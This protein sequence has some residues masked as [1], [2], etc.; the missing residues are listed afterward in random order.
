MKTLIL[1]SLLTIFTFSIN[2]QGRRSTIYTDALK[3]DKNMERIGSV[4][5]VIGGVSL[6]IGNVLYW[7]VYH[8]NSGTSSDY[9][10]TY[11]DVMLGG[12]G[13]LAVGIPVWSAGK[14]NE[15]HIRIDAQLVRFKGVASTN[16]IGFKIRF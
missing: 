4:L 5:T 6:F 15:R 7:R 16:G 14:A 8:D 1:V 13:L 10:K 11:R 12:L 2:A 9:V 3:R